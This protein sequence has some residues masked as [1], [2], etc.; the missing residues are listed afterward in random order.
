IL[1]IVTTPGMRISV[2]AKLYE[3]LGAG[4]PILA[5]AEPD[6]DVARVL[7]SSGVP[8]RVAPPLDA[9][10]IAQALRELTQEIRDGRLALAAPDRLAPFTRAG[11]A[12]QMA[13]TLNECVLGPDRVKTAAIPM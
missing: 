12:Q 4:R 6:G 11:M 10:R 8:H 1:L 3:Y 9:G 5:L 2:P 7:Q 13:H